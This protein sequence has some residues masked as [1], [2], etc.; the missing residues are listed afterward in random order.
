MCSSMESHLRPSVA[1]KLA[2]D[3]RLNKSIVA[4][5]SCNDLCVAISEAGPAWKEFA[6]CIQDSGDLDGLDTRNSSGF[7]HIWIIDHQ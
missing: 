4:R 3:D 2:M 6:A 1:E 7:D 5:S